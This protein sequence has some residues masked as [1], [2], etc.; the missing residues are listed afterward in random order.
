MNAKLMKYP[1]DSR[2][3][4]IKKPS[5]PLPSIFTSVRHSGFSTAQRV[6]GRDE[7]RDDERSSNSRDS[8][9]F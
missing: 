1:N 7:Q 4:P 9:A 6:A 2:D 5:D 3:T 8:W